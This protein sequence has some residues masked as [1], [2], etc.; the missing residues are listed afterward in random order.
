MLTDI[1]T[2]GKLIC[3]HLKIGFEI[4]FAGYEKKTK[5]IK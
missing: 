3:N 4:G 1:I 2:Q 5:K